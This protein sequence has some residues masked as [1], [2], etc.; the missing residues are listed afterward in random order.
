MPLD[1]STRQDDLWVLQVVGT[2]F[3]RSVVL[4][5]RTGKTTSVESTYEDAR[6]RNQKDNQSGTQASMD[7][8]SRKCRMD[9]SDDV[10]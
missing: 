3:I 5:T 2:V 9:L 8:V 1:E 7:S 6:K 4:E 10:F